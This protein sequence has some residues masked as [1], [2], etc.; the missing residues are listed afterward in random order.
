MTA[1]RRRLSNGRRLDALTLIAAAR[2]SA[3]GTKSLPSAPRPCISRMVAVGLGA[4]SISME[5][6]DMVKA[7]AN[8]T[9]GAT[10]GVVKK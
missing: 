4:V 3:I 9:D 2:A 8:G 7:R 6:R 10:L 5:G 1:A